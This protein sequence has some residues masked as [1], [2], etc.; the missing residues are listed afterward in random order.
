ML[1]LQARDDHIAMLIT[2]YLKTPTPGLANQFG[3]PD[4]IAQGTCGMGWPPKG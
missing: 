1:E 4:A 3:G 2:G